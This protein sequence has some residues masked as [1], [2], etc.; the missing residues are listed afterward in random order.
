[1][2]EGVE[3]ASGRERVLEGRCN[4]RAK[5]RLLKLSPER[6]GVVKLLSDGRVC[7]S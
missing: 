6:K 7:W 5:G 1:M 4:K 2:K 3:A